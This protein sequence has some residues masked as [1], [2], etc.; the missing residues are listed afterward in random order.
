M[1]SSSS[2]DIL[3]NFRKIKLPR[4]DVT[5]EQALKNEKYVFIV[6]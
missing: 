4:L 5:I 1:E 6:D 2:T 3:K